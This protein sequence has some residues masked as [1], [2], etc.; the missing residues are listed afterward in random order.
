MEKG[1]WLDQILIGVLNFLNE[2]WVSNT[3]VVVAAF[4]VAYFAVVSPKEDDWSLLREGAGKI[5][6]GAFVLLAMLKSGPRLII[7]ESH[8]VC[9]REP[10]ALG[11]EVST[12]CRFETQGTFRTVYDYSILDFIKD[13]Y[14]SVF[15]E[16]VFGAVG[17]LAGLLCA[18][19]VMRGRTAPRV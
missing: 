4:L 12:N 3:V 13:F 6:F 9:D 11:I 1:G 14:T 8:Y 16:L 19:L 18:M 10:G 5:L 17:A 2:P 15:Y 7:P